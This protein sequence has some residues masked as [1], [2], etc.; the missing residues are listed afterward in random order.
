ME[1]LRCY[2]RHMLKHNFAALAGCM[3]SYSACRDSDIAEDVQPESVQPLG[4][5]AVQITWQDGFNQARLGL[6]VAPC[7]VINGCYPF[8]PYGSKVPGRFSEWHNRAWEAR[9]QSFTKE[10]LPTLAKL[11]LSGM[12]AA[13]LSSRVYTSTMREHCRSD[14][15]SVGAMQVAPFE[16]LASL[17]EYT[18]PQYSVPVIDSV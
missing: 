5:Y 14:C 1:F 8:L 9:S 12:P 16:L 13:M 18:P 17:P 15:K 6:L 3:S 11:P 10:V 2:R 7:Y 4:N